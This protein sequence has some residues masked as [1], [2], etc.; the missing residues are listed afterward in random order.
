MQLHG[1]PCRGAEGLAEARGEQET[2]L[3][4]GDGDAEQDR[5]DR[6]DVYGLTQGTVHP[7]A[8]QGP[9]DGAHEAGLVPSKAE[10]PHRE[11]YDGV[12]GPRMEGPVEIRVLYPH[13]GGLGRLCLGHAEG[14]CAVV[15]EGLGDTPEDEG[16]PHPGLEK[17]REPR[18]RSELGRLALLAEPKLP[19]TAE[20]QDDHED[21]EEVP[22][23][24][25]EPAQVRDDPVEDRLGNGAEVRRRDH[26]P[27]DERQGYGSRDPEYDAYL[28]PVSLCVLHRRPSF[29]RFRRRSRRL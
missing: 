14:R 9:E 24:E 23:Q 4:K 5:E 21:E 1:Y 27:Q 18:E 15:G 8:Q 20:R 13:L 22:C 3:P 28:V 25:V 12:H 10:V 26:T 16:G 2:R 11:P 17:H 7:V 19:V 6:Q 29:R